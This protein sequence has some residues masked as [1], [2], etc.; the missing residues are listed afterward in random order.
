MQALISKAARYFDLHLLQTFSRCGVEYFYCNFIFVV[1]FLDAMAIN[2]IICFIYNLQMHKQS[3][4]GDTLYTFFNDVGCRGDE[5]KLVDCSRS[6]VTLCF[7]NEIA[8]VVCPEGV[9][10]TS[11]QL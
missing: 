7:Q 1:Q 6:R 9:V 11:M 5:A 4:F 10:D 8:G 2:I 3:S